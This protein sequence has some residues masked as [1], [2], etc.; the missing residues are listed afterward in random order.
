[1]SL[2]IAHPSV[3]KGVWQK[4]LAKHQENGERSLFRIR[5]FSADF[6][7]LGFDLGK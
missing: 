6:S 4:A 2:R 7:S 1:M 3:A 5:L